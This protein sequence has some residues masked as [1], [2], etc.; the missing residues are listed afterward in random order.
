MEIGI[1]G[2]GAAG[3][4]LAKKVAEAGHT[5]VSLSDPGK[6]VSSIARTEIVILSDEW[7]N[8]PGLVQA[9]VLHLQGT[10]LI[11]TTNPFVGNKP[12]RLEQPSSLVVTDLAP[13]AIVVKAFNHFA[14]SWL[15]G[16]AASHDGKRIAFIAG[17]DESAN[18]RVAVLISSIGFRVVDLG[19][20]DQGGRL[21]EPGFPLYGLSLIDY[22]H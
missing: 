19:D 22:Q 9:A 15:A 2:T 12:V 4:V 17:N 7:D 10:I 13:G 14:V 18:E 11:D 8:V 16:D 3:R 6:E 20:L 5:V 1:L 21:I